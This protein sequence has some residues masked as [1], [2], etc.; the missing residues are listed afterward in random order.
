MTR[1]DDIFIVHNT[2]IHHS[3]FLHY[4]D[5][6]VQ[7]NVFD[8]DFLCN[9]QNYNTDMTQTARISVYKSAQMSCTAGVTQL[10][11]RLRFYLTYTFTGNVKFLADLL[12]S[13]ASA[14]VKPEAELYDVLLARRERVQLAV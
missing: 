12:E 13:T 10:A 14:V 8:S 5:F 2:P 7:Y 9:R 3:R 1:S 6:F 4:H 11:Q